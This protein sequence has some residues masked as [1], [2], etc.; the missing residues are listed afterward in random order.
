MESQHHVQ[1]EGAASAIFV[2]GVGFSYSQ[3][4]V[5]HDVSLDIAPGK[6]TS[7]VGPNGCGKSTLLHNISRIEKPSVGVIT[8][9]RRNVH[10][11]PSR[12]VAEVLGLLAQSHCIPEQLTVEDLVRRGRYP[13]RRAWQSWSDEDQEAVDEAFQLTELGALRHKLV[14]EL[15]GG[16]AQR[17]F[18]AMALAQRTQVLL[19]D[20]PTTYLDLAF[21]C[22]VMRVIRRLNALR[23]TTVCMVLHD[24]ADAAQYSDAVVMMKNGRVVAHGPPRDILTAESVLDVFGVECITMD[25]PVDGT[26]LILPIAQD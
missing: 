9:G 5:L 18:L 24:L 25:H 7:I 8:L 21:R 2:D 10:T 3:S 23:G 13:H 19:L 14:D 26:P 4:P 20:E 15:S 11:T 1:G 22:E 6:I 12:Q 16:Q 17:A